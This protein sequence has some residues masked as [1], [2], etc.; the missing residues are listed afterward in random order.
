MCLQC[1]CTCAWN[2]QENC[3][4]PFDRQL[5][6]G[7]LDGGPDDLPMKSMTVAKVKLELVVH[8]SGVRGPVSDQL[9]RCIPNR[10]ASKEGEMSRAEER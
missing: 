8:W 5:S 6:S 10:V 2:S 1:T 3:P 4:R 7:R 9:K